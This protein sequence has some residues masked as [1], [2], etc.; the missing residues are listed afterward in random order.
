[1]K[2][3]S[4]GALIS[5]LTIAFFLFAFGCIAQEVAEGQTLAFDRRILLTLRDPADPAA[6]I[7]P[8]W[9]QEAARDKRVSAA[10]SCWRSS[11]VRLP[12]TCFWPIGGQRRG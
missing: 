5:G 6:P 4:A 10:M 8:A 12:V 11:P 2:F 1:M 9:L 3:R 7:G